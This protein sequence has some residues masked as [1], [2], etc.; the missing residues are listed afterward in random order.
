M[1]R[2]KGRRLSTNW[3]KNM[4]G[5]SPNLDWKK[6]HLSSSILF[7]GNSEHPLS[8]LA[9]FTK[10]TGLLKELGMAVR[11]LCENAVQALFNKVSLNLVELL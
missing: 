11:I 4:C 9:N 6:P 5:A 8:A 10:G 2:Q 3:V 7:C 1:C